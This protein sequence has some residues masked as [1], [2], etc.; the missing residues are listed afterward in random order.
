MRYV[1][2][3]K[4]RFAVKVAEIRS[5]DRLAPASDARKQSA[6]AARLAARGAGCDRC[7]CYR[8]G[9]FRQKR[10]A[11]PTSCRVTFAL[12][13]ERRCQRQQSRHKQG[14]P[15]RSG[16]AF[17]GHRHFARFEQV[18]E[19]GERSA[20]RRSPRDLHR[21]RQPEEARGFR[22]HGSR[23]LGNAVPRWRGVGRISLHG[24][25][26]ENWRVW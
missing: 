26:R 13:G 14:R 4:V 21:G 19:V 23:A 12:T 9:L 2:A 17:G 7:F 22:D 3:R 10:H 16:Q 15:L 8:S 25:R 24:E 20:A 5:A 18:D 1:S 6:L 11:F